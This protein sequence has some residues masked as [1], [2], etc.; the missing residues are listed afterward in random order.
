MRSY[1]VFA[2]VALV[3]AGGCKAKAGDVCRCA[4][5]CRDGLVCAAGASVLDP[6][7]CFAGDKTG[8]CIEDDNLPDESGGPSTPDPL[9]D[10]PSKRDLGG[11][12]TTGDT[13]T[14]DTGD[15]DTTDTT[16]TTDTDTTDTT[17]TGTSDTTDTGTSDTGTTGTTS[18][19]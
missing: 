6:E 17:D 11:G 7:A 8:E 19:T 1:V 14:T 18:T 9:D 3:A 15:A 10:L 12:E 5:D 13:G 4:A 16:D 2:W